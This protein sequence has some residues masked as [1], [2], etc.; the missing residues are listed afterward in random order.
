MET[1]KKIENIISE[2]IQPELDKN[3]DEDRRWSQSAWKGGHCWELSAT[4]FNIPRLITLTM[5]DTKIEVHISNT[6]K[7]VSPDLKGFTER[8]N[9]VAIT[10]TKTDITFNEEC[11]F[12]HF[13]REDV[14]DLYT[15]I[16]NLLK[17][18]VYNEP[19]KVIQNKTEEQ[20]RIVHGG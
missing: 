20:L 15:R 11:N 19:G 4:R 13:S 14:Y 10:I 1:F 3:I 9:N 17:P 12:N 8:D 18:K 2:W 5:S 7:F 16:K 6:K